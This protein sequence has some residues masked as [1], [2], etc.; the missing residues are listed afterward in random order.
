MLRSGLCDYSDAY[1]V[2]K[3]RITVEGNTLNN[4]ANKKLA[5]K[6]N[7]SFKSCKINNTFTD[8]AEDLDTVMQMYNL[9]EYN[10]NYYMTLGN[11]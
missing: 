5:I 11:V 2:V 6:N 4:R 10:D 1:I 8:N 9:L 7:A 3:V